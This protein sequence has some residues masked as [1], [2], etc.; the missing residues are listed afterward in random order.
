[1]A[2][3]NRAPE[4]GGASPECDATPRLP[5]ARLAG[6]DGGAQR[7]RFADH[8]AE[9]FARCWTPASASRARSSRPFNRLVDTE[10][11][12]FDGERVILPQATHDAWDAYA[13]S[14]MLG[15][16]QDRHRRHAAA[17]HTVEMAANAF[18]AMASV[19]IGATC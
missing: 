1:M 11:P 4:P 18:F 2:P 7:A 14:G 5:A 17:L 16:A 15:A 10:E 13:E 12:R 6:V 3:P 8:S 19:S 9:T